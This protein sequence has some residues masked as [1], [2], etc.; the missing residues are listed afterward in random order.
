MSRRKEM[1]EWASSS[2]TSRNLLRHS[3]VSAIRDGTIE[4]HCITPIELLRWTCEGATHPDKRMSGIWEK[5][6]LRPIT[7]VKITPRENLS[8]RVAFLKMSDC[9][10]RIDDD[11]IWRRG[12]SNSKL[13]SYTHG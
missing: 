11:S 4:L 3:A 10:A 1:I 9:H 2:L 8:L 13:G 6:L 7:V 5:T 12:K